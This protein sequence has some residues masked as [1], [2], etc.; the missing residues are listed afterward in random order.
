V[1]PQPVA[2]PLV[3]LNPTYQISQNTAIGVQF[4]VNKQINLGDIIDIQLDSH[5]L[6]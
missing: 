3:I 1:Y 2:V 4:T 5:N 6:I